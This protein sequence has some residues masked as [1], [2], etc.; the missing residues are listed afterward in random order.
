MKGLNKR[1]IVAKSAGFCWGV[2][3]AF[4]KVMRIAEQ[5]PVRNPVFTYGP[6]IHN[7]QAVE[8]LEHKGI[9]VLKEIPAKIQGTI[10][11]RTHGVP[12]DERRRLE[13]TGAAI[14]DATCPDVGMI[15][16]TVRKHLRQGYFIIIIGD[17]EHP[18]VKALLGFAEK[19]GTCVI[20]TEEV[21]K[22]PAE[23]EKVCVVSQSTQQRAKFEELVAIIRNRY[24]K[25]IVFDTICRST[26][27]RQEEVRELAKEVDA[28]VVVGGRNSSNTNRLAEISR[29]MG[30]PTFLI[31][32]DEEIDAEK[33]GEFD[34]IGVTAGASTPKWVIEQV[35]ARLTEIA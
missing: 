25:S 4:E 8:V 24:P 5:E 7:P 21:A 9:R 12:P 1:I 28:M 22:L 29:E 2:S 10:V 23:L 14:C 32:S 30:T 31:E 34:A 3:R 26:N 11:I 33:F 6:L 13:S 18:E 15:Q 20:S 16:G 27:I 17:R 35:V 19:N